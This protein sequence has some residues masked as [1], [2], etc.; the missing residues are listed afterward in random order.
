MKILIV[1]MNAELCFRLKMPYRQ[2]DPARALLMRPFNESF[3]RGLSLINN[4]DISLVD[5][6]NYISAFL[7]NKYCTF[8][9]NSIKT[10]RPE[11]GN[12]E[13]CKVI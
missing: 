5:S 13:I 7:E 11:G 9:T 8:R 1:Q 6:S 12:P 2:S 3:N 4:H 10:Y